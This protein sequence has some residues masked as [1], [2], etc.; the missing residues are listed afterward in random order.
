[1][2]KGEIG[3]RSGKGF[4]DYSTVNIDAMFKNRYKGFVEL[5]NLVTRSEVLNFRGGIRDE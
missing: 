4:F 5:L 3:P 1:M 2:K